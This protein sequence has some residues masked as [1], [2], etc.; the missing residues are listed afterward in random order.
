MVVRNEPDAPQGHVLLAR[1][2]LALDNLDP[3][4]LALRAREH[5]EIAARMAPRRRDFARLLRNAEA[6]V[7]NPTADRSLLPRIVARLRLAVGKLRRL[8][9]RAA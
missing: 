7:A 5:A 2:L 1:S 4:A 8:G 9:R 3:R 6:R